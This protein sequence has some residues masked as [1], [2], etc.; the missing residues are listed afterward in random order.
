MND[1]SFY[2]EQLLLDGFEMR[3]SGFTIKYNVK[4]KRY[5]AFKWFV[6]RYHNESFSD[7]KTWCARRGK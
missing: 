3:Y 4:M 2:G 7:V 6:L 1:I 5:E